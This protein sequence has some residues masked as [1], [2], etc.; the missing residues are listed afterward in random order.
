MPVPIPE[1]DGSDSDSP[2]GAESLFHTPLR[3][4]STMT[5]STDLYDEGAIYLLYDATGFNRSGPPGGEPN[6]RTS[7]PRSSTKEGGN[8]VTPA[9]EAVSSKDQGA[10]TASRSIDSK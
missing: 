2:R 6:Y 8:A 7:S 5:M 1:A 9:K 10:R 4:R 3:K